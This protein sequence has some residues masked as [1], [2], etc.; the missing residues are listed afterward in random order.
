MSLEIAVYGVSST[1]LAEKTP[2]AVCLGDRE[3]IAAYLLTETGEGDL[4]LLA[5]KGHETYEITADGRHPFD[6][7]QIVL[8]TIR[9][10]SL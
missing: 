6:E 1:L 5:G 7:E 4:I 3:T 8:D 10:K 9:H 2:G